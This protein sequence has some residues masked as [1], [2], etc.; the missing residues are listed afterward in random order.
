MQGIPFQDSHEQQRIFA[1]VC[2]LVRTPTLPVLQP[3]RQ[4][5]ADGA[6]AA[7]AGAA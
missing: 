5:R 6:G 3:D 7:A 2:H 1:L 4:R